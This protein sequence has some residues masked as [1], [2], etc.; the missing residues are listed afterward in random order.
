MKLRPAT[1]DDVDTIDMAIGN[2]RVARDDLREAGA[3][4]AALAVSRAIK[5]AEGAL[6]HAERRVRASR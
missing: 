4:R 6:R 2:L 1:E 5:S 3:V